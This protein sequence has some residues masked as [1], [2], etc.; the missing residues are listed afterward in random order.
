MSPS[1]FSL[2]ASPARPRRGHIRSSK[3][4][5]LYTHGGRG[6]IC[7]PLSQDHSFS[8]PL[9]FF[10]R[11]NHHPFE[12]A[13][14]CR[15]MV[16]PRARVRSSCAGRR[17]VEHESR[18]HRC[19][20]QWGRSWRHQQHRFGFEPGDEA[21]GVQ[22][23]G[24]RGRP[25]ATGHCISPVPVLIMQVAMDAAGKS[26]AAFH[27]RLSCSR[28]GSA[29]SARP[30]WP[31]AHGSAECAARSAAAKPVVER[32]HPAA[33]ASRQHQKGLGGPFRLNQADLLSSGVVSDVGQ[34]PS[35]CGLRQLP[36]CGLGA[37][38]PLGRS[39][40]SLLDR[41]VPATRC[42]TPPSPEMFTT[43]WPLAVMVH[44]SPHARETLRCQHAQTHSPRPRHGAL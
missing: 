26:T 25:S 9:H 16:G 40:W 7:A 1:F 17:S 27:T 24:H 14:S 11:C 38:G 41:W 12:S 19:C 20:R 42:E 28:A 4:A 13:M 34:Q 22:Q 31:D 36:P 5:D 30:Q 35:V 2:H 23:P 33:P 43:H 15:L 10:A 8:S 44:P 29:I 32:G 3:T 6:C 21:D 39:A 18:G 37:A